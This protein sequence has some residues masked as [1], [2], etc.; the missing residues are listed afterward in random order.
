[1][2]LK[3]LNI[4]NILS[5]KNYTN[6]NIYKKLIYVNVYFVFCILYFVITDFIL[7]I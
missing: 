2:K 6:D 4:N 7:H 3:P 5:I 1:M